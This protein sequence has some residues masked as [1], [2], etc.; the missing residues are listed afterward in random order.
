MRM[1]PSDSVR[2]YRPADQSERIEHF[3]GQSKRKVAKSQS[4]I[5]SRLSLRSVER[6]SN[7]RSVGTSS[8]A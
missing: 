8:G 1:I 3:A 4:G 2:L 7:E 5:R 6:S